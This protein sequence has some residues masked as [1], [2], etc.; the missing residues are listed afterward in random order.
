MAFIAK[1]FSPIGG[2][3]KKGV[4]P[5]MWSYKTEDAHGTVD[6]TGY[7]NDLSSTL[8][9]GDLIYVLVVTNLGA[10]NEATS[11][12]GFHVVVSNSGGVVDVADVESGTVT[13]SD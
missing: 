13:D 9:I 4:A 6:T 3:S 1:N 5:C 11:T 2:Q 7:F 8:T 10:S 12:W